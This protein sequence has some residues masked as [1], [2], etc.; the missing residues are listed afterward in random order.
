MMIAAIA[1]SR[2]ADRISPKRIVRIGLLLL[3]VGLIGTMAT[4]DP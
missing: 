3:F 4:I 2:V 1:G